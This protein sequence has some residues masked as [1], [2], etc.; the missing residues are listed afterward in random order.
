[1]S[2]SKTG[3]TIAALMVVLGGAGYAWWGV[4]SV[5]TLS[6]A[7]GSAAKR[8]IAAFDLPA[9]ASEVTKITVMGPDGNMPEIALRDFNIQAGKQSDLKA[10]FTKQCAQF[11][12]QDPDAYDLQIEP[13]TLCVKSQAGESLRFLM[14]INCKPKTCLISLELRRLDF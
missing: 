12:M 9:E 8:Y 14:Y 1:M 5:A 4:S 13:D 6:F 10:F 2:L 11:G 3:L 7:W